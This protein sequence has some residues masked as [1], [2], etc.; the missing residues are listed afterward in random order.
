MEI[1]TAEDSFRYLKPYL[2]KDDSVLDVGSGTGLVAA[3]ISKVVAKL[4]C[5]DVID[6]NKTKIPLKLYNGTDLPFPD[7]L[8]S[9]SIC[10]F[11]LHHT[12]NQQR[13][14]AEIKRVT[15]S[16]ILIMEDIPIF[17]FDKISLKVHCWISRFKYQ[18]SKL[19][20]HSIAEWLSMF[21][22]HG[23]EV[24]EVIKINRFRQWHYPIGRRLFVLKIKS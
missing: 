15:K 7:K 18:S 12:L 17:F 10:C 2:S 5:V 24:K 22:K 3:R 9:K 19:K 6:I 20:F 8:F 23:L 11:S 13:L 1:N 14:L 4:E 16:N 21:N